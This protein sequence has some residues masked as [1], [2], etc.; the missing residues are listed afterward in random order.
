MHRFKINCFLLIVLPLLS[1]AQGGVELKINYEPETEYRQLMIT[2]TNSIINYSGSM[3]VL[4]YLKEV[5]VENPTEL[6][7]VIIVETLFSTGEED[8]NGYFPLE[9]EYINSDN[10]QGEK[11]VPD[12]TKIFGTGSVNEK[13]TFNSVFS[14]DLDEE[15]KQILLES[16]QNLINQIDFPEKYLEIGESFELITPLT[17][18]LAEVSIDM[19]I[20]TNYKLSSIE[21]EIANFEIIQHISMISEFLQYQAFATG[22]GK[23]HM[24]YDISFKNISELEIENEMTLNVDFGG[25]VMNLNQRGLSIKKLTFNSQ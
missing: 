18:P 2:K 15:F 24:S 23:G 21:N 19:I 17:F 5:G 3:E 13:P 9:I 16:V 12:G 11:I 8:S 10:G 4:N 20:T 6:E 14:P 25:I 22:Q 7:Q 1:V